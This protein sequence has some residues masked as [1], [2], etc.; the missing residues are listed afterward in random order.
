MKLTKEIII[1]MGFNIVNNDI[2]YYNGH[3]VGQLDLFIGNNLSSIIYEL[4][5]TLKNSEEF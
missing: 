4:V 2:I 3:Y 1:E 5:Y